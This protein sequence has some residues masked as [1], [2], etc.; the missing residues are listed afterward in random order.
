MKVE[1]RQKLARE[2]FEKKIHKVGQLIRLAKTF[3][4]NEPLSVQEA[5]SPYKATDVINQGILK[6]PK[7]N[8]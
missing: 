4:A 7:S 1:M 3:R 8:G 6:L 5:Q 2:T